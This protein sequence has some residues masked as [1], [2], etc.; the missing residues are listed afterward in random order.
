MTDFAE[1][2]LLDHARSQLCGWVALADGEQVVQELRDFWIAVKAAKQVVA[3]TEGR[4]EVKLVAVV[5]DE[6]HVQRPA[7]GGHERRCEGGGSARE[8]SRRSRHGQ[9][10][11]VPG[12]CKNY[13]QAGR[14][15]IFGV[16]LTGF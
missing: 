3:V 6:A 12:W 1:A 13:G 7:W 5:R 9:V 16:I 11:G 8:K 10:G 2:V 15:T 14:W 4:F